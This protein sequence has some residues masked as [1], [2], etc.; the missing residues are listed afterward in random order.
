ML[1]GLASI[2]EV[3]LT[4]IV[5]VG[6]DDLIYGLYLSP[7]LDTV[8][9]TLAGLQSETRG[10]GRTDESWQVMDELARFPIDSSFRIGDRDLALNLYRTSRLAEGVTLSAVTGEI[11]KA[12][13]IGCT[14]LPMSDDPVRTKLEVGGTWVDFQDYFVRLRHAVP[15]T[16]VK[17]QGAETSRPA[18]GVIE[19]LEQSDAV[20]IGPSNPI[21]SIWPMLAIPGVRETLEGRRVMVV[22]P[23]IGG[24]AIKGPLADLLPVFGYTLDTAGIVASYDGLISDVVVHHGDETSVDTGARVYVSDTYIAEHPAA[25]RLAEEMISWLG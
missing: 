2:A 4:A 24:A 9:Y 12:F 20:V 21:L 11:T 22:S 19:A 23:L 16:N 18:P 1:R 8:T 15:V 10:W 13:G 5:N 25:I 14:I 6:D 17:F 3:E 7:D